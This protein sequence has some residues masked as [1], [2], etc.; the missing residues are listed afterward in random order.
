MK[1]IKIKN[2]FNNLYIL[3]ILAILFIII[4]GITMNMKEPYA[5]TPYTYE[6][7]FVP[8][9][10]AR[11]SPD[12]TNPLKFN[13]PPA[14]QYQD[15]P[16]MYSSNEDHPNNTIRTMTSQNYTSCVNS[17]I[18]EP[19]CKGIVTDFKQSDRGTCDLKNK[20]DDTTR[21]TISNKYSTRINQHSTDTL[22]KMN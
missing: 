18:T 5:Y 17:C 14:Y 2:K 15:T 21:K 11:Y 8:T 16:I 3:A 20:M 22:S 13:S 19:T 7:G 10:V 4:M 1:K 9:H 6:T 12:S